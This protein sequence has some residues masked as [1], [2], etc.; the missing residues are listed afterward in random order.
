MGPY[1]NESGFNNAACGWQQLL[2]ARLLAELAALRCAFQM[3]AAAT[4]AKARCFLT[5]LG[6]KITNS[7]RNYRIWT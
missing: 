3:V 5:N 2:A 1:E 6:N 7:T 4:A